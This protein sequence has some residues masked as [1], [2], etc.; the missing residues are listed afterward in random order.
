MPH[1]PP[2][3]HVHLAHTNTQFTHTLGSR[4][5]HAISHCPQLSE[6][7]K[8][9]EES[10]LPLLGTE[11]QGSRPGAK[12]GGVLE[13]TCLVARLKTKHTHDGEEQGGPG[14][15]SRHK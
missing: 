13:A 12:P 4:I 3:R 6:N 8:G 5:I 11:L 2:H 1:H 9:D 7:P 15:L 14:E 10:S